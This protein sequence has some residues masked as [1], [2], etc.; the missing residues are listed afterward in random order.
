MSRGARRVRSAEPAHGAPHTA[1]HR[2]CSAAD[3]PGGARPAP[4]APVSSRG[5]GERKS[6]PSRADAHDRPADGPDDPV[7]QPGSVG[8]C[9]GRRVGWRAARPLGRTAS[10]RRVRDRRPDRSRT[11]AHTPGRRVPESP[12]GRNT[13]R[14]SSKTIRSDLM[15][16]WNGLIRLAAASSRSR[17]SGDAAPDPHASPAARLPYVRVVSFGAGPAQRPQSP[18]KLLCGVKNRWVTDGEHARVNSHER[19][20]PCSTRITIRRLSIMGLVRQMASEM[21]RPAA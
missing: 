17:G 4:Y 16:E 13:G 10:N 9:D 12:R 2:R 7:A 19:R 14:A 6:D 18:R 21:R 3:G 8:A 20:S 15:G 11:P 5:G 1:A